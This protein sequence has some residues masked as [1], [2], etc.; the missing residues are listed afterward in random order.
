M[1]CEFVLWQRW[2][3]DFRSILKNPVDVDL[4]LCR[5]SSVSMTCH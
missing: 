3:A 2:G 1:G 5:M 4:T